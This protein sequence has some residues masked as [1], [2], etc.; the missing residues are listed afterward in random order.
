MTYSRDCGRRRQVRRPVPHGRRA[1]C[2]TVPAPG[3]PQPGPAS[4]EGIDATREARIQRTLSRFGPKLLHLRNSFGG[5][6]AKSLRFVAGRMGIC[7]IRAT[8]SC[9]ERF[10]ETLSDFGR[11]LANYKREDLLLWKEN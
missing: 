6:A 7:H 4:G 2:P 1:R 8:L 3:P 5:C 9:H 11:L 10:R